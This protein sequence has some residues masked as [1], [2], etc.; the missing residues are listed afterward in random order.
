MRTCDVAPEPGPYLFP[1][2]RNFDGLTNSFNACPGTRAGVCLVRA[3]IGNVQYGP[4]GLAMH[5]VDIVAL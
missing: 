1:A 5:R 2:L 3:L 4:A